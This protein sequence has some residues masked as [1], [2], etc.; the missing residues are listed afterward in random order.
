MTGREKS[1][2]SA[3]LSPTRGAMR[4]IVWFVSL[5]PEERI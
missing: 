4:K 2:P 1:S 5:A 3:G